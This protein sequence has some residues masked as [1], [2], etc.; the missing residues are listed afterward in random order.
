M[1]TPRRVMRPLGWWA[2]AVALAMGCTAREPATTL[3]A[4]SSV[5][6]AWRQG[7]RDSALAS[8]IACELAGT[9]EGVERRCI[10]VAYQE[11]TVEYVLRLRHDDMTGIAAS[12]GARLEV[13]LTKD[14]ANATVARLA[15][16]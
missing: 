6:H 7:P 12:D 11:T 4:P 15:V 13:R 5:D 2:A 3:S 10:V 16:P 1:V 9:I 14:G 8:A